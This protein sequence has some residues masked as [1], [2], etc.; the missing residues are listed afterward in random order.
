MAFKYAFNTW[1]YSS[2][3]CW[4]PSYPL[5]EAIRRL[6]TIGY[7]GI[8]IGCAA[9]HAWPA[10]LSKSRRAE[11]RSLMADVGLKPVSLLP[12]PGGGPGN[13][14]ASLLEEERKSTIQHYKEVIDLAQDLG[15]DRVLYICGWRSYGTSFDQA[16]EW[17]R[18]ALAEIAAHAR[19]KGIGISIEPTS[20]DSNLVDTPG[21][22]LKL[23]AEVGLPNLKV[24]F[25]TF[26][27]HY[28]NEV[29][30]DYV[31]E[32]AEHL[33]HVHFAD[34]NR[35]PPGEGTIDWRGVMAALKKVG[36]AGYITMEA[37]FNT[38]AVEPDRVARSALAYLKEL[39]SRIDT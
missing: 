22:A 14:P 31:F 26:H 25:D 4:V 6:A 33:D 17:T 30:S 13:N 20:A 39:E 2:F 34:T 19:D 28:R 21:Q 23:R 7:D 37:G 1:V 9:P 38:R 36:F 8:E 10:H 27:A 32:M 11:L 3:P 5:D 15:A 12:A 18:N 16:W 35:L 24:M 29:S